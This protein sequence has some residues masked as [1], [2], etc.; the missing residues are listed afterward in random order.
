MWT[1]GFNNRLAD[2]IPSLKITIIEP[3]QTITT[4]MVAFQI[5]DV[6]HLK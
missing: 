3:T 5:P 1:S 4:K 2:T 6:M